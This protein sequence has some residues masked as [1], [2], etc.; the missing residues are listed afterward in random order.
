MNYELHNK[1]DVFTKVKKVID[2]H[3]GRAGAALA[4]GDQYAARPGLGHAAGDGAHAGGGHQLHGD[5]RVLVGA[6]Q[7]IDE[8]RQIL[9]GVDVVVGRGRDQR[10]AGRGA[11]GLGHAVRHL[12]AG[13]MAA[14]AGLRALG[15][16]DL[17]F[18]RAQQ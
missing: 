17:Y 2:R 18:L 16:L 6:L 4:A 9:D 1:Y 13:Q 8:F 7:V 10:Y 12:R 15:H 3:G 11:A 5:L 14:L